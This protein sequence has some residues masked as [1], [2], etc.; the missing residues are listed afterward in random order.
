MRLGIFGGTFDPIHRGHVDSVRAVRRALELD[1]VLILPTAN[2][3]HKLGPRSASALQRFAMAE[4]A[5]LD[6]PELTVSSL[7]MAGSETSYT[8]DTLHELR[9][10]HPDDQLFLIVGADSFVQL[11]TWRRWTRI[12]EQVE[13]AVMV[14]PGWSLREHERSLP[15]EQRRAIEAGRVHLVENPP[16][17]LSASQIR[18]KLRDGTSSPLDAINPRVLRYIEKYGLYR[19]GPKPID[20]VR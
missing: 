14:R 9:G 16:I 11:S 1:R 18:V 20:R 19:G 17:D 6:E 12:L 5:L 10:D 13:L 15:A 2:P 3:P 8:V 4:L 7:E